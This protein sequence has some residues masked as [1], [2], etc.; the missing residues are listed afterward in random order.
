MLG[1]CSTIYP[2]QSS[3]QVLVRVGDKPEVYPAKGVAGAYVSPVVLAAL[4]YQDKPDTAVF[5]E[6]QRFA[7]KAL[8]GWHRVPLTKYECSPG[9]IC[10]GEVGEQLWVY[11]P[12]R[13]CE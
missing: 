8:A 10:V 11:A 9:R 7:D 13:K 1:G 6:Q 4:A 3:D 5:G 2:F 12:N